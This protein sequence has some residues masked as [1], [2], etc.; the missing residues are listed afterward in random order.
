MDNYGKS[1]P[2]ENFI[3]RAFS[4]DV[5]THHADACHMR[6]LLDAEDGKRHSFLPKHKVQLKKV[7]EAT[8]K[9]FQKFHSKKGSPVQRTTLENLLL[10]SQRAMSE[11]DLLEIIKL[12]LEVTGQSI[13]AG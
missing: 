13:P 1:F 6:N 3:R 7:R 2:Y 10:R 5:T 11:Y 8:V 12:G 4:C 9:A